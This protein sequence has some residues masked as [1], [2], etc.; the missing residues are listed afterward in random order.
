MSTKTKRLKWGKIALAITTVVAL[1]FGAGYGI[2]WSSKGNSAEELK[3]AQQSPIMDAQIRALGWENAEPSHLYF[4]ELQ[5]KVR[6]GD[7]QL[8]VKAPLDSPT[9]I[10]V[11]LPP[12]ERNVAIVVRPLVITPFGKL[13]EFRGNY[14]LSGCFLEL[15]PQN[16]GEMK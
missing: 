13:K 12:K 3:G 5:G 14:A 1:L 16:T 4:S 9:N 6:F 11:E 8:R 7:C 2:V 10:S 15:V